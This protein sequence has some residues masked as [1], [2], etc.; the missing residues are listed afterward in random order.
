MTALFTFFEIFGLL[1]NNLTSVDL[2]Q[3][4]G[5]LPKILF[6]SMKVF[7]IYIF[8]I[9][10]TVSYGG[11]KGLSQEF[12]WEL[13]WPNT[14]FSWHMRNFIARMKNKR[15]LL[16]C[17]LNLLSYFLAYKFIKTFYNPLQ[18]T[19]CFIICKPNKLSVD[20]YFWSLDQC[21][22]HTCNY[23]FCISFHH[24]YMTFQ[25]RFQTVF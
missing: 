1:F 21:I 13:D 8:L 11:A 14:I 24:E 3:S 23:R 7:Y 10:F 17:L 9:H 12:I 20:L 2:C 19:S 22:I 4:T 25:K 18:V 15:I 5:K 16:K 6:K